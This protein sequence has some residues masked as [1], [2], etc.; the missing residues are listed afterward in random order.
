[1]KIYYQQMMPACGNPGLFCDLGGN[2]DNVVD[3]QE[4]G[5]SPED[6]LAVICCYTGE[7]KV[8]F[9]DYLEQIREVHCVLLLNPTSMICFSFVHAHESWF[10]F[11]LIVHSQLLIFDISIQ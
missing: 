11:F 1:M 7:K 5:C 6:I 2:I 9:A 10:L 8:F 4:K 3:G